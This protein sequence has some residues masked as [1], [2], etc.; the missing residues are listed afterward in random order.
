ML[1]TIIVLV[2][3]FIPFSV[4]ALQDQCDICVP[5]ADYCTPDW[6]PLPNLNRDP[7]YPLQSG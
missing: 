3:A 5:N 1:A 2:F 7:V 4:D 6:Q